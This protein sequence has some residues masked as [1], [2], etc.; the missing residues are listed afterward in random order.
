VARGKSENEKNHDSAMNTPKQ[1]S[2]TAD[3]ASRCRAGMRKGRE[4]P[5]RRDAQRNREDRE[6]PFPLVRKRHT[7]HPGSSH[8]GESRD[9]PPG[10]NPRTACRLVDS[11]AKAALG[12][13]L[14]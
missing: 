6:A 14:P 13:G 11:A 1:R 12:F 2:G 10:R 4:T 7:R 9:R 5:I 3:S 8:Q